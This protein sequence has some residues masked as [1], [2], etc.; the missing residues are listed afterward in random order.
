MRRFTFLLVALTMILSCYAASLTPQE[1]LQRV[2]TSAPALK[3]SSGSFFQKLC[4][5]TRLVKTGTTT[6]GAAAYYV[7]TNNSGTLFVSADDIAEPLLGYT[8]TP[9]FNLQKMP[10]QLEWWLGMYTKEIEWASKNL[11]PGNLPVKTKGESKAADTRQPISPLLTTTWGQSDPFNKYCPVYLNE[12]TVTGCVA[13]AMAQVMNY[14]KWPTT[15]VDPISYTWKGENLTSPAT[16]FNWSKM[17][18]SY[19]NSYTNT[20]A[21]AVARLM[22]VA[23][24]SVEMNY[25]IASYGGS[26]AYSSDVRSALVNIFGYD[27]GTDYLLRDYFSAEEW[28][29]YIYNNLANIGPLFYNGQGTDGGHAFV[30]DGYDGNGMYHINWGWSGTS[31]GYFKL[32]A[33]DPYDL[34][35]GGGAGGFNYNQGAI[36]GMQR[37][38]ANSSDPTPYMACTGHLNGYTEGRDLFFTAIS[39][40]GNTGFFNNSSFTGSFTLGAMLQDIETGQYSYIPG[41]Y[42][43][44]ELESYYGFYEYPVEFDSSF[45]SGTYI[46]KPAYNCNNKGWQPVR[47]IEGNKSSLKIK[48]T[49]GYPEIIGNDI[50]GDHGDFALDNWLCP[51]GFISGQPYEG[52]L[53]V[54]STYSSP[55]DCTLTALLCTE[56]DG[57]FYIEEEL[58]TVTATIPANGSAEMLFKGTL[59]KMTPGYYYLVFADENYNI[60]GYID[61][62]V[63]TATAEDGEITLDIWNCPNGFVS[64]Q[65]YEGILTVSSTYS[66]PK[67]Y[68]LTAILCTVS[69]GS[70]YAEVELNTVT[71]T[72]PARGSAE[73]LF[74]GTLPEMNPGTYILAFVDEDF[75]LVDYI[76]VYVNS[77]NVESEITL[78]S[79]D[80]DTGFVSGEHY[81]GTL[82]VMST[83]ST[84]QDYSLDA[85]LCV[86]NNNQYSI[87]AELGSSSVTIPA[88]SEA[89]MEFDGTLAYLDAGTYHLVFAQ[90]YSVVG[91][92]EVVVSSNGD[93]Y[94]NGFNLNSNILVPG[95]ES[96]VIAIMSS[97]YT[98]PKDIF[99][100][101]YLCS[102]TDDDR[103]SI[104]HQYGAQTATLEAETTTNVIFNTV[105]P[106]N[107]PDGD[108]YLVLVNEAGSV[109][110]YINVKVD[111][112]GNSGITDSIS[113]NDD[114]DIKYYDMNGIEVSNKNLTP[115]L[116]IRV[117]GKKASK[118]LIKK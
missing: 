26:G 53:T 45:P 3:S 48:I 68:T 50:P 9:D 118:V 64:G 20:Q 108:Y 35:T 37:P 92:L 18:D 83:Y 39:D 105:I 117:E 4:T 22:Q 113:D 106:D 98:T 10:P 66:T 34:G 100:A 102:L 78:V 24:Y 49:N 96:S 88:N 73:M 5:N 89:E 104:E 31:D 95:E 52:I 47:F 80:S 85:Y 99:L 30:C 111:S 38:Q 23:G 91:W 77:G 1:A 36:L 72:I 86:I 82:T 14:F 40:D 79:W 65:P 21:D 17:L 109:L 103:F 110:D 28:D 44:V 63:T 93:I 54:S 84:P 11:K 25:D 6:L 57:T 46:V 19:L 15:Q 71:A 56:T 114:S 2:S 97:T 29:N 16:T 12:R 55:K 112:N 76:E 58:N 41:Y 13:T 59:P 115:G 67:D 7:F 94:C 107:I 75:Y 116:Y 69:D 90:N 74:K 62:E 70:L 81:H 61:V 87:V 60:V 51:T 27:K 8:E 43:N 101:L 32:S 33:L 42:Q